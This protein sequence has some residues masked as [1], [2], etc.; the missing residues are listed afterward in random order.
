MPSA[1]PLIQ[2]QGVDVVYKDGT[3]GL[4]DVS[5]S[6][7]KGELTAIC[8]PNGGGKTTLLKAIMGV[9]PVARG[10]MKVLGEKVDFKQLVGKV[11]YLFQNPDEQLF[12]ETVE[13]E[14]AFGPRNLGK[15]GANLDA[16]LDLFNLRSLRQRHPLTLSRGERQRLAVASLLIMDPQ[17]LL[18][19]EPTTGLDR[20]SWMQLMEGIK[21]M[22]HRGTTVLFATH[23]QEAVDRYAH[24]MIRLERGEIV[25]DQVL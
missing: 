11:A 23:H 3:L 7:Q 15:N 14:L 12:A 4:R 24:R 10:E 22:H 1:P 25:D 18:L 16:F 19:D 9:V 20:S 21:T 13:E 5:L 8:G 17:I 6:F 2:F